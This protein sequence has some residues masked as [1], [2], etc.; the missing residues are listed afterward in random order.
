ML[1][2]TVDREDEYSAAEPYVVEDSLQDEGGEADISFDTETYHLSHNL[3]HS[4]LTK[5]EEI[6]LARK[7]QRG[8]EDSFLKMFNANLRLVVVIAKRYKNASEKV[9]FSDLIAEG[10]IGL[11]TAIRKFDPEKGF[12]FSTYATQWISVSITRTLSNEARTVRWPVH[13]VQLE[14][15]YRKLHADQE[16]KNLPPLTDHEVMKALSIGRELLWFLKNVNRNEV[17]TSVPAFE[18]D[19]GTLGDE[20][21]ADSDTL[22]D[23]FPLNEII[24]KTDL[25]VAFARV[26]KEREEFVLQMRFGLAREVMTLDEVG[27]ILNLTR[28]RVR[29]IEVVA[30][31][32][33]KRYF[34][35][36][37][38][39]SPFK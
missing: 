39:E 24:T 30:L 13:F 36:E 10:N 20:L 28:E 17:S 23:E 14:Y 22:G 8:C 1:D 29:Q 9:M 37:G 19:K 34:E 16:D 26:L 33:M 12:R 25:K 2:S 31:K 27:D 18:E 5:G 11:M 21:F 32:K 7:V 38:I 4:L 15:R 3:K 35:I 6:E